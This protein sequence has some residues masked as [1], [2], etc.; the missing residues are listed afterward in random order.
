MS[1][2]QRIDPHRGRTDHSPSRR[3]RQTTPF[4]GAPPLL[5]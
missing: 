4:E 3:Y 2:R 5:A 1:A